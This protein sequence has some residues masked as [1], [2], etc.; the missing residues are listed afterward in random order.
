MSELDAEPRLHGVLVTYRRP[1]LLRTSLAAVAAQERPLD[2]L[3]VV[4]NSPDT[5]NERA[6]HG[7]IPGA[8]Y[9]PATENLGPAGGIAEGMDR[10]LPTAEARD[11]IAVLDDNDPATDPRTFSTLWAFAHKQYRR[12]GTTG[13]VGLSGIRFDRRRGRVVR[14]PD[15]ELHGAVGVDCFGG[16][17]FPM[18][19]V[20]AV[21]T[22]GPPRR[23]LFFGLEELE[24]GLRLRDAGYA[25]YGHGP[26]WHEARAGGGRLGTRFSPALTLAEPTWRRYYSL[27][28]LILILRAIGCTRTAIRVT[29]VAG[30]AK[31][32]VNLPVHPRQALRNLRVNSRACR[33]AWTGRTGRRIEPGEI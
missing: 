6:V 4:D 22:V 8:H 7:T 11:W 2:S 12:D 25:L 30:M 3:I 20:R 29:V 10:I 5:A 26:M 24:F 27:R 31:P 13:G 23:D 18:Y 17:Q 9:L 15:D 16:N 14:V 1:A 19:S 21:R 28:N 32:L 33:D